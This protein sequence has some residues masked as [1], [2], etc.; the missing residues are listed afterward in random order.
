MTYWYPGIIDI[1]KIF[2]KWFKDTPIILGGIYATLCEQHA[3]DNI[4]VEI[5]H[6]GRGETF[7]LNY[8]KEKFG[9][10]IKEYDYNDMDQ[11]PYPAYNLYKNPDSALIETSQGCPYNCKYC[12][13]KYLI[14]DFKRRAPERVIA[15]IEYYYHELKIVN[16]AFADDALLFGDEFGTILEMIR[17]SSMKCK[18]FTPNGIHVSKITEKIAEL[19]FEV[20]FSELRL[21]IESMDDEFHK[22]MDRKLSSSEFVQAVRILRETGFKRSQIGAYVMVG[23]PLQTYEDAKRSLDFVIESGA[24]PYITQYSPIPHSLLFDDACRLSVYDLASEPLFHNN[25]IL[26]MKW[27]KFGWDDLY[28]LKQYVKG[29]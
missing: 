16:F 22:Y 8:I 24:K 1:V 11:F 19:M 26:P 17:K 21:G 28:K 25:S 12:S 18:F 14:P 13:S 5:V 15:E 2:R 4:G 6:P 3:K 7:I 23:L 9:I 10:N 20:G 27:E 29:Y